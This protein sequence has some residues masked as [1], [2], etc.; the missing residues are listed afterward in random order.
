M[1]AAED[2][3]AMLDEIPFFKPLLNGYSSFTP[4]HYRWLPDLLETPLS[5]EALQLLRGFDVRHVVAREDLSLPLA[6]RVGADRVD[7][8][9]EGGH[10]RAVAC[11][12]QGQAALWDDLSVTL[13]LQA[14][15]RVSRVVFELGDAV[16]VGEPQAS[17]SSDGTRF[18]PVEARLLAAGAVR[19]LAE[20]PRRA[21][22]EVLLAAPETAR[23]LRIA[24]APLRTGGRVSAE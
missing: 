4:P 20:N 12:E 21:C 24:N 22:A 6:A 1:G 8:V 7:A 3:R 10:A 13:D 9:P 15:R 5:E 17:L 16:P 23:F 14:E 2:A 11:P 19:A 18:R